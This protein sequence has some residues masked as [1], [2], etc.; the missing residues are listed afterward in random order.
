VSLRERERELEGRRR[1]SRRCN[2][3]FGWSTAERTQG[4]GKASWPV[5][6]RSV[7]STLLSLRI[8]RL[9]RSPRFAQEVE[10]TSLHLLGFHEE[11]VS[12]SRFLAYSS[13]ISLH[14]K[15]NGAECRRSEGP[16][17]VLLRGG[18]NN[19]RVFRVRCVHWMVRGF[20]FFG[21]VGN[22]LV[23]LWQFFI[24]S[25]LWRIAESR[26]AFCISRSQVSGNAGGV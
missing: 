12:F 1:A 14:H 6:S 13:E 5:F 17:F 25:A 26:P 19:I 2:S 3:E 22:I 18:L 8:F 16:F 20:S 4:E 10:N 23:I 24:S 7:S 11:T 9:Y 15:T 21:F